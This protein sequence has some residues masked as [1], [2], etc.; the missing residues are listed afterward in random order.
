MGYEN[1]GCQVMLIKKMFDHFDSNTKTVC[2]CDSTR[3]GGK[4]MK[5]GLNTHD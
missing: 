1:D 5:Q 2:E 3:D 4:L